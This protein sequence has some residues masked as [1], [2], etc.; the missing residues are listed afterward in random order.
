M[1]GGGKIFKLIHSGEADEV[2][3]LLSKKPGVVHKTNRD[4]ETPLQ[5][6]LRWE[7]NVVVKLLISNGANVDAKDKNGKR[8]LHLAK[9]R[10]QIEMLLE[11]GA[12]INAQDNEGCSP[13][14]GAAFLGKLSIVEAL[15]E[16]GA[17]I[18]FEDNTGETPVHKVLLFVEVHDKPYTSGMPS[19]IP[20]S[21]EYNKVLQYLLLNGAN[22]NHRDLE[23]KTPLQKAVS[24][25]NQIQVKL[26][27]DAGAEIKSGFI[28]E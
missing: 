3:S 27:V 17:D 22:P 6:A 15:V 9:G 25:R 8:P 13:L 24:Y 5:D 1:F 28:K 23:G 7:D 11:N 2:K 19:S 4:G 26:L 10:Y 21:S 18:N 12:N 20:P 14:H 16:N